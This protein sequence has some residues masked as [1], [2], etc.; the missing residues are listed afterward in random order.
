MLKIKMNK[1]KA[2]LTEID[3]IKFGSQKEAKRYLYLKQLEKN[4][5][6]KQLN[7][8]T[9]YKIIDKNDKFR[10]AYYED[11]FSYFKDGK[12]II[13]DV[14]GYKGGKSYTVFMLKKKIMYDKYGIEVQ[15]V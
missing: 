14:K 15:E 11:D 3:G 7:C 5:E 10:A 6:I 8:K 9:R 1:Y 12:F 2:K 13:E 4:G